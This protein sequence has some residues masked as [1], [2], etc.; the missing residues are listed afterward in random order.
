MLLSDE[1]LVL[2][3]P[4]GHR[5]AR[6]RRL[7]LKDLEGEP[8]L[9]FPRSLSPGLYDLILAAFQRI[10]T[11]PAIVQEATQ[12]QT[13]I[14]F[15]CAG[16]GVAIVPESMAQLARPGVRY[17]PFSG[18]MPRIQTV[19]VLNRENQSMAVEKLVAFAGHTLPKSG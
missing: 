9:S 10:G 3:A 18:R 16:L 19:I 15:V 12:L 14:A 5:F 17:L 6:A 8:L 11:A 1:A 13:L 2:A 4:E 7:R